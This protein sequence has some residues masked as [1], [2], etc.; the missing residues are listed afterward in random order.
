MTDYGITF[1]EERHTYRDFGLIC[2]SIQIGLPE[3]KSKLIEL[4]GA[5]GYLDLTEVFGR[6]MYGNRTIKAEFVLKEKNAEDWAANISNIANYLH[7]RMRRFIL[8]SDPDFY[9][10]G[11]IEEEH[12]KE[13]RP[14][15]K[16]V[17]TFDCKPYKK[18]LQDSVEGDW[19]WDSLDLEDGVIREY[20]NIE[21][22]GTYSL[23]IYGLEQIQVPVIYSTGSM[24]V[25]YN[26]K[27]HNLSAGRNYIY[28]ITIQPGDNILVFNGR[29]TISVEYRGGK[30]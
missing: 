30:L 11:R 3:V 20:G 5:D 21:V 13:Y 7:G 27:T 29:G 15:S 16:V 25:T 17:L 28:A 6:A 4:K 24:T 14:F 1:D 23:N 2:T 18:E 12:E 26:N 9:Y 19:L 8:D 22:N 10:E